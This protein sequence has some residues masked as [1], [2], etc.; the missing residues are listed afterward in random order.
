MPK[1][2]DLEFL[3]GC[4]GSKNCGGLTR[5]TAIMNVAS[6]LAH[7]SYPETVLDAFIAGRMKEDELASAVV[8]ELARRFPEFWSLPMGAPVTDEMKQGVVREFLGIFI[9]GVLPSC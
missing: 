3:Q 4:C 7:G 2:Q 8:M 9:K 6:S 5:G 1:F